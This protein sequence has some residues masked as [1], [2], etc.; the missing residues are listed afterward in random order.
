MSNVG[1]SALAYASWALA[2]LAGY[3]GH[4]LIRQVRAYHRHFK[5]RRRSTN[6]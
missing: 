5:L 6:G 2:F 1:F 3:L 4:H